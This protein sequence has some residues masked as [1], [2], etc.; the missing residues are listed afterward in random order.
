MRQENR[1]EKTG[2]PAIFRRGMR[3]LWTAIRTEPAVFLLATLGASLHAAVSVA[4][5]TVLGHVTDTVILPA[6]DEGRTTVAAL[7]TAAA[8]LF[9]VGVVKALGLGA[10]RLFAGL[11]QF[12]MQA[13]YRRKV[14]RKY[15]RLPMSWHHRHPAGQLLSN[16]NA[17]VEAAWGPLAPLPMA[18]GS[19]FMFVIAAVVMV[20]TDPL[21]ATVGFIVF[22]LL[23]MVNLV[24]Q[25]RVSPAATRA[26]ALRAEVSEVA[27]ESFDG[28][29]VVKSL[30]REDTET[31]RFTS[32]A[33]RLRDAQIRVGRM[34][35]MFDPVIEA[36]PNLG[37]LA[38]LAVGAWRLATGNVAAGDLVEVAYLFTLLAQPTRSFGW[39]LGDLPRSVVGWSRVQNVL[40]TGGAMEHG[41]T[42]LEGDGGIRLSAHGVGFSYED[43]FDASPPTGTGA[44][45]GQDLADTT[46]PT[47]TRRTTV[48]SDVNLDIAAGSTVAV[49]GPTGSGKS[50][51]THL[52]VR[53][54]DPDT[55]T[56][57]MDGADTRDLARGEIAASA[58]LVPQEAFIFDDTVRG[59]VLLG[60]EEETND[61]D[62]WA[63]L[64]VAH[65]DSFVAALPHGLDT[66]LGERGT[67]LSGGQ[68]QRL[69]LARAV[70]RT[71]RLLVLDD[72]TSAVDPQIEAGIL[73][74][75]G[76]ITTRTTEQQHTAAGCTVLVVAYRRATIELAD[77]V[78]YM[79]Q[80]TVRDR[81]SHSELLR[82][83]PGYNRLV[84]A[85]E[86]AAS[87]HHDGQTDPDAIPEAATEVLQ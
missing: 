11:M 83:S 45:S 68:R 3:V 54:V 50:T 59:N 22:P 52:L 21:L 4:S 12:R 13:R 14:A 20:A 73:S 48:L 41:T 63:A 37:V 23:I 77:E 1:P 84:T 7:A 36:L 85:Y 30:G 51:L 70:A 26:Q 31:R 27:H 16:A 29:L 47:E 8:L 32:A 81:G 55:G 38:V 43:A 24:F 64:R 35:G 58:A 62:V 86:R 39:L 33:N 44:S 60:T 57:R 42:R 69:A 67:T 17:D 34:R 18:I 9:G 75:L 74:G 87:H 80:G 56:V 79:E 71:P 78:I 61:A 25:R 2:E 65:A 72:A 49:V 46:Q 6:F 5:A 66:E 40:A 82:R 15:L 53:L 10:R 76:E 19:L 28:A